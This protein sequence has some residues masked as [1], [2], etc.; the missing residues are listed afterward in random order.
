MSTRPVESA[1]DRLSHVLQV[2]LDA[3][4][5]ALAAEFEAK[6]KEAKEARPKRGS[7]LEEPTYTRVRQ[8]TLTSHNSA[9]LRS[10]GRF[11]NKQKSEQTHNQQRRTDKTNQCPVEYRCI[12]ET[13]WKTA[14]S[15]AHA[16]EALGIWAPLVRAV[17]NGDQHQT[18]GYEF[19]KVVLTIEGEHWKSIDGFQVSN[20]GRVQT[21][22]C[23]PYYPRPDAFTGYCKIGKRENGRIKKAAVHILVCSAFIGPP[24]SAT[25]TVDHINRCKNDNRAENLRW[26]TR[27]EQSSNRSDYKIHA[28]RKPVLCGYGDEWTRYASISE[29]VQITGVD[30]ASISAAL[31]EKQSKAGG[32]FWKLDV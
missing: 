2:G 21:Q 20:F 29:A 25:H 32:M 19:R 18:H 28:R 31:M 5:S 27:S 13:C 22:R 24:P 30:Q 17:L 12:G 1:V 15:Q 14:P 10:I 7:L 8:L 9:V 4:A 11:E 3:N 6:A 26:A 16:A 23:P